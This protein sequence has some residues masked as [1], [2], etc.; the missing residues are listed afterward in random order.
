M[1]IDWDKIEPCGKTTLG[2]DKKIYLDHLPHSAKGVQWKLTVGMEL[3]VLYDNKEYTI[4]VKECRD[5]RKLV[6]DLIGDDYNEIDF[7]ISDNNLYKCK[8]GRLI[9]NIYV[10][11]TIP[12]RQ[13]IIDS[14]G[15]EE[16]KKHT[17]SQGVRIPIK[18]PNCGLTT[19]LAIHNITGSGFTCKYCTSGISY[20][21]RLMRETLKELKIEYKMQYKIKDYNFRYDFYLKKHN[22]IL[23]TH[24]IQHYVEV[25]EKGIHGQI[26]KDKENDAEKERVALENGI[27]KN[28]YHQI[29]CRKS[30]LEWCKQHFIKALKQYSNIEGLT[31]EQ[32][33]NI[34]ARAERKYSSLVDVCNTYNKTKDSFTTVINF[35]KDYFPELRRK[36]VNDMLVKGSDLGICDYKRQYKRKNK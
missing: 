31:D 8:I 13:L 29:D 5:N 23:E 4:K 6:I 35:Q 3:Y 16:A 10:N 20:P 25:G 22:A 30:E 28:N 7:I 14:I 17:C 12:N 18:C 32:W 9:R 1:K 34:G 15:E 19:Y 24:G 33:N 11:K 27:A 2:N 21:E 26:S 36:E